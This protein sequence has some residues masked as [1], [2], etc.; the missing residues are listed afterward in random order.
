MLGERLRLS[1]IITLVAFAMAVSRRAR[2]V[3]PA[4][5]RI[6]AWDIHK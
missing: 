4:R 3:M 5:I 1:G 6:P 2:E